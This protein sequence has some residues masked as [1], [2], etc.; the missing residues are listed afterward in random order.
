[1]NT[2]MNWIRAYVPDLD[3]TPKEWTDAMTL[4]GTKVETCTI[5]DKNLEKIVTG[6]I[7]SIDKHPNADKLVICQVDIGADQP[8]QI[9]TG[10][11][12]MRVGDV[13]PVVQDGGKVAG[14]HD[15][16]PL[17]ED[18]VPIHAG[19]LRGVES[20]GMMCS[21]EELGSSR[22]FYPEAPVSGLYIFPEGTPVGED[23][24]TLL[25]LHDAIH[26]YEITSNRV[27]CYS[28]LGIAR[29]AAATFG[30]T[31]VMPKEE[32][33][34]NSEDVHDFLK[35]TVEDTDL[36]PRYTARM[37]KN[38]H[39]A[40]SPKWMQIRLASAGIRPINNI[41]DITNYVMLEYG[42]PMHSYDYDKIKGH[43][44]IVKRAQDGDIFET[45]DQQERKLDHTVLTICDEDGAIGLAGI[46]GGQNSKITDD[47]K[48]MVFEAATFDG[49][50]IRL[51]ARKVGDR[52][53]ASAYFEKGLDPNLAEAAINRACALIEELNAGE[54]VGGMIDVY[55]VKRE[56]SVVKC[57]ASEINHLIGIDLTPEQMKEYLEKIELH[58][59][60]NG[61]ELTVT[62]PTF[63]Q[64]IHRMC[65]IAE[66]VTRFYGYAKVPMTLPDSSAIAGGLMPDL[67]VNERV[68]HYAQA[69]GYSQAFMYSFESPKVYDKLLFPEDAKERQQVKI[70]NPLGE[71]FSVM[72]TSSMNGMLSS[73][74]TNY[75][76]KNKV[77]RLY[78][79]ANV[80]IPKALPLTE[81]PDE[82]M[83]LTLGEIGEGD[84]FTMKGDVEDIL[85]ELGMTDR[86]KYDA[87]SCTVPYLHPGRRATIY[88]D[89]KAI[90][91]LGEVHPT[92]LENYSIGEKAYVA[93]LD[94]PEIY[95]FVNDDIKYTPLA[96]F[97][98]V[99][100]DFSM[101]VPKDITAG[102]IED[103]LR[104]RTGKLCENV[105]LFDIYEGAQV[106][107]GYKSMAYK[108]TLRA[109][110][111]TLT[112]DEINGTVKKIL[113]GLDG[114]GIKLRS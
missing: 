99:A 11:S 113:N 102:K 66:E 16:G 108:V 106:L 110:D 4:T 23:A 65:D 97:P 25:G 84:F 37:V 7:L 31:F 24:P 29:E 13:V 8:L 30:K 114:L 70:S 107:S 49:T 112:D 63:R 38:I 52:T 56:P 79:L 18:G 67:A 10:A 35:V 47:V 78:E 95:P 33:S 74:S 89:G 40:P 26:E 93:V 20:Y 46:M 101:L 75:N 71:D 103:V 62:A 2:S 61:D 28:V 39:L 100:R 5:L 9:V 92:V 76:R 77:A 51:S 22:E 50:N 3:C 43:H 15:G 68:R 69:L 109:Q 82:R 73:L 91:F 83:T 98:A 45:L 36:C 34:G 27:D 42:Q 12:N 72:R 60:I 32:K 64:D 41:V 1:M 59:E 19:K 80:Y 55:P 58:T 6:K 88:Y 85:E 17:P 94:M 90:G 105:E 14:G 57:T 104:Q 53:D 48:T 111:H 54:V 96:K 21:I 87:E 81:L 44:I 86:F